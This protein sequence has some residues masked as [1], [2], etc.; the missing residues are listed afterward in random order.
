[1][2]NIEFEKSK[3]QF[4]RKWGQGKMGSTPYFSLTIWVRITEYGKTI[5][6]FTLP[7]HILDRGNNRQIVF[8]EDE[9]L[10]YFLKLLK[11]YKKE[12]KFISQNGKQ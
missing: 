12:L 10:A 9:Q 4:V 2:E 3:F 1:L 8:L 5:I 11:R 7:F 6:V